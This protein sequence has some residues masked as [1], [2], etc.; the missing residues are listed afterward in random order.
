LT[1]DRGQKAEDRGQQV[2]IKSADFR[3][4]AS[5]LR[6]QTAKRF[7]IGRRPSQRSEGVKMGEYDAVVIGAGNGGLTAAATMAQKGLN[8]LLL[9]RHNIPG[10]KKPSLDES[11][12]DKKKPG[13]LNR[14]IDL[15]GT[16]PAGDIRRQHGVN[17]IFAAGS[18]SHQA[19]ALFLQ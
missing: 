17:A 16:P 11:G 8:I 3:L 19:K 18:R 5:D 14:V 13:W 1:E 10:G 12:R 6:P 9:E 2:Q 4:Q 7:S 15:C